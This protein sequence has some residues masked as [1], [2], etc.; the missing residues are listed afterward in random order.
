[1][2][3]FYT[4]DLIFLISSYGYCLLD[5]TSTKNTSYTYLTK[6]QFNKQPN[7]GQRIVNS[8]YFKVQKEKHAQNFKYCALE[9]GST[10]LWYSK[11][12]FFD[13][14]YFILRC[15]DPRKLQYIYS[16]IYNVLSN[17][18]FIIREKKCLKK[19]SFF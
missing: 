6:K 11:K 19:N 9:I 13:A 17:F 4:T 10:I 14:L 2:Q 7:P 3:F 12:I 18:Y 15:S 8:K 5:F 16:G 1:M